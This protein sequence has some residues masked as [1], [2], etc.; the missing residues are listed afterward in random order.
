MV[1][2]SR[3]AQVSGL[4]WNDQDATKLCIHPQFGTWHAYRAVV[5]LREQDEECDSS[6]TTAMQPPPLSCPVS[7][8][9]LE[10]AQRQMQVALQLVC[11][12]SYTGGS[13]SWHKN[14][15]G[16]DDNSN[17]LEKAKSLL[18]NELHPPSSASTGVTSHK[19]GNGR[20]KKDESHLSNVQVSRSLQ[21]WMDLRDCISLGRDEYKYS[22]A[23]L[24]Y[25]YTRDPKILKHEIEKQCES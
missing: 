16:S 15:D 20:D 17:L 25:H 18:G 24:L 5:V 3:V 22:Q 10:L 23:Q 6:T 12:T 2:M 21:A 8:E 14:N 13:A 9:E 1:C 11:E 7:P 4:C 19:N